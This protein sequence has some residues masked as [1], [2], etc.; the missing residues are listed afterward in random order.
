M[1]NVILELESQRVRVRWENTRGTCRESLGKAEAKVDTLEASSEFLGLGKAVAKSGTLETSLREGEGDREGEATKIRARVVTIF[2]GIARQ[3]KAHLTT[4]KADLEQ[5][6]LE[7][8]KLE[9]RTDHHHRDLENLAFTLDVTF[10]MARLQDR[11]ASLQEREQE[12]ADLKARF[13]EREREAADLKAQ[14]ANLEQGALDLKASL[15]ERDPE[16]A[17]MKAQVARLVSLGAL[18]NLHVARTLEAQVASFATQVA[19]FATRVASLE[20][21]VARLRAS[22]EKGDRERNDLKCQIQYYDT[23][24]KFSKRRAGRG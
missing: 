19:S 7:A 20:A 17:D 10:S 14:V 21:K 15:E 9:L 22:L 24:L 5:R 13:E 2:E 16:A 23:L 3:L 1:K 4:L 8:L 6:E 12:A 18:R 11:E